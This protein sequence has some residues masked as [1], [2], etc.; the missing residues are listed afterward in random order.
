MAKYSVQ[1]DGKVHELGESGVHSWL[2]ADKLTGLE[3]VRTLDDDQW[4]PLH[5]LPVFK[6]AVPHVGD[7][8][9]V[10][11]RRLARGFAWHL[12][13]YA[14]VAIGLLGITSLPSLL[15][16][17]FVLTHA[18]RALPAT[19]ALAR[20]GK[21]LGPGA[22]AGALPPAREAAGTPALGDGGGDAARS[23][24]ATGASEAGAVA[25]PAQGEA[26][27]LVADVR[28][29][30]ARHDGDADASSRLD[31][32]AASLRDLRDRI[33]RLSALLAAQDRGVLEQQLAAART[34]LDETTDP[35]DLALRRREV[36]V[37]REGLDA[38]GRARRALERLELRERL[39]LQ[40]LRQL[41]LELAR[42]EADAPEPD[43]LDA[44]LEQIRLETEATAEADALV[45]DRS[46]PTNDG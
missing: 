6:Q 21:L 41:R 39:G 42:L 29:M 44:R 25:R 38:D 31:G 34:T 10:A 28:S 14:A 1:K 8:R 16:G 18:I 43:D 30:L 33:V 40:Q 20:E 22:S 46:R 17:F 9:D 35:D 32:V 36:E 2:Q 45:S 37:L 26:E 4:R 15:W 27:A 24:G 12:I 19:F 5:E 23:A 13:I 7:P 3:L 11:R